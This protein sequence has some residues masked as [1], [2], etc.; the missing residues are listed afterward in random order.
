MFRKVGE[1]MLNNRKITVIGSQMD[2][3][4]VRKGVDMGPLAIRHAGLITKIRDMG[5]EVKD[6]LELCAFFLGGFISVQRGGTVADQAQV[7]CLQFIKVYP[8][9][10]KAVTVKD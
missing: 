6:F 1:E 4:A 7:I 3:G 10:I 5:F 8:V 2:L 9:C